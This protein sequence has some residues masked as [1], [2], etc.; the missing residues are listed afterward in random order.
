LSPVSI[1]QME[2]ECPVDGCDYTGEPASVEGHVS[3]R[4]DA[5]HGGLTGV[6]VRADLDEQARD[7]EDAADVEPAGSVVPAGAGAA[8]AG[9][10]VLLGDEGPSTA[11]L[12]AGVVL[13][14]VVAY[15]LVG[16]SGSEPESADRESGEQVVR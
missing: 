10:P 1:Y 7:Q 6:D 15:L 3:S 9:L 14:A 4:T 11:A 5:G 2:I 8:A 13:V 16:G 12:V